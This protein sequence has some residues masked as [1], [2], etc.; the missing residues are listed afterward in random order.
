MT[1]TFIAVFSVLFFM[2]IVTTVVLWA[3]L[4]TLTALVSNL[5][6]GMAKLYDEIEIFSLTDR[7]SWIDEDELEY[8]TDNG[9]W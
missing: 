5:N 2:Q 4:D 6:D 8:D 1:T 3:S 7:S 9:F